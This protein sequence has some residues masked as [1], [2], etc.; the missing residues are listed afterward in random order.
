MGYFRG[1]DG[2]GPSPRG[3]GS[4]RYLSAWPGWSRSIPAWAGEPRAAWSRRPCSGVH[5]R[6][7]GGAADGQVRDVDKPGP[8]PR[9]RGSPGCACARRPCSRSIPAW[10]GE[11]CSRGSSRTSGRVH[12]RVG[13]GA[14]ARRD[15]ADLI[16]GP[17]PRGRG[18]HPGAR[19]GPSRPGSIPAWAGE[20]DFFA[21]WTRASKVHPRVGGGALH[22]GPEAHAEPRVHPR[23]G[24]GAAPASRLARR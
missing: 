8:S 20:P 16:G 2:Y 4:L 13:G 12:P 9:G 6:V 23:V 17:S 14:A 15:M 7:G 18:S 21:M 5:P 19:G 22:A 11:P 3:R 1:G 24:G 10:A